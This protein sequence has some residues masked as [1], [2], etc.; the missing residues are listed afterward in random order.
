[1]VTVN[2]TA[3]TCS[4]MKSISLGTT[5]STNSTS[6]TDVTGMSIASV[7]NGA[8]ILFS[9]FL[10]KSTGGTMDARLTDGTNVFWTETGISSNQ[11]A[12]SIDGSVTQN[13]GGVATV[14]LQ[15]KSSD[16]NNAN[17]QVASSG[18]AWFCVTDSSNILVFAPTDTTTAFAEAQ[19]EFN[20]KRQIDTIYGAYCRGSN[21]SDTDF[22]VNIAGMNVDATTQDITVNEQSM[23]IDCITSKITVIVGDTTPVWKDSF[24]RSVIIIGYS[25]YNIEVTG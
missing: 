17:V 6:W 25:G 5:F 20:G 10:S 18:A 19:I 12:L 14:K 7:S 3:V 24:G 8:K 15:I 13:S 16:S 2:S 23:D 9:L 22:S 1:M 11:H 4:F 21:A